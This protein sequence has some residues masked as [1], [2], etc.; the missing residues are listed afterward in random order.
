VAAVLTDSPSLTSLHLHNH[1]FDE[2]AA[3]ALARALAGNG[4]LRALSLR[5]STVGDQVR[6]PRRPMPCGLSWFYT[7]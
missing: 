7:S 1:S 5:G 3:S 2:V 4:R 6:R